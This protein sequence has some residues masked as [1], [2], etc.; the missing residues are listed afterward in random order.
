MTIYEANFSFC[1]LMNPRRQLGAESK[2]SPSPEFCQALQML[3]GPDQHL[4]I[5]AIMLIMIRGGWECR[6]RREKETQVERRHI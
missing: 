1:V 4:I 3:P 2:H 6:A 5:M